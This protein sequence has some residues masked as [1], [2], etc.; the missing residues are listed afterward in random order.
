[1]IHVKSFNITEN[2]SE[3]EKII[4]KRFAQTMNQ[5]VE[6]V[7]SLIKN[8]VLVKMIIKSNITDKNTKVNADFSCLVSII[9]GFVINLLEDIDSGDSM[10][11]VAHLAIGLNT[12]LITRLLGSL[13]S[14]NAINQFIDDY[15]AIHTME[16]NAL[17]FM[18]GCREDK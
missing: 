10:S 3:D 5:K 13:K 9:S 1:M 17:K 4:F 12:S 18:P 2:L 8:S 6:E 11:G 16:V 7:A 15:L 14:Q